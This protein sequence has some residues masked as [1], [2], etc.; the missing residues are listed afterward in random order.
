MKK[1]H[2][3]ACIICLLIA[4]A[5]SSEIRAAE[6]GKVIGSI[7]T[8]GNVVVTDSQIFLKI[9]SRA[10][11][12]FD[13]ATAGE[14]VKRIAGLEGIETS[15]YN[16]KVV[17]GEIKLTFVVVERNL[18][19]SITFDGNRK[20]KDKKLTKKLGIKRGDFLD[21]V[22]V[23]EGRK[24]VQNYYHTKGYAFARVDVET[25][26]FALGKLSFS[27]DEG[28]RVKINSIGF[29]GN[30]AIASRKLS[31]VLRVKKNKFL[32]FPNYYV[33]EHIE[34]DVTGLQNVYYERGFLNIKIEALKKFNSGRDK[35]DII[36]AIEEGPVYKVGEIVFKAIEHYDQGR[37]RD[38]FGLKQGDVYNKL[39]AEKGIK[40]I[41]KL[42]RENGFVD[43]KVESSI[44]FSSGD[45]VDVVF[46]VT[47]GQRFRIGRVVITGNEETQDKVVRRILDEYDF[48]PGK[49]YNADLARG[50]GS[51]Y[52]EKLVRRKAYTQDAIIAPAGEVPGQKE[53][54]VN[55]TEGQT[56]SVMLGAGV[57]SD[58]GVIGQ[59]VFQQRNFDIKDKPKSLGE[60]ITGKAFKGAGQMLRIALEPGT[61]LS[62]YSISFTEPYLY[63]RP[64]S[65][66][67]V[68][69]DYERERESYDE[70]RLKGYLGFEKRYRNHWR[71]RVGFRVEDVDMASLEDDAPQEIIDDKGSNLIAGIKI[72]AGKDLTD[73]IFNP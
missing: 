53:A 65:M 7:E 24:E 39:G 1:S 28:P 70:E 22:I 62:R 41:L 35:A 67:I 25:A 34:K 12:V 71:R 3:L 31:K 32:I 55:V 64:I 14:D 2:F 49:W 33:Q 37:L 11:D 9:R 42:Y 10:G 19:R 52:L 54:Q 66:N 60:F 4:G 48:Q 45:V 68:G 51:G 69:S 30:E 23:E 63:N 36:Y 44:R 61:E 18:V 26:G 59:L 8:A 50:D 16:T 20:F 6:D 57:A 56:G 73:D 38:E 43:A 29:K 5:V 17:N 47:E 13:T 58:S 15:Y 21:T 72:G 40:A 27:V 46:D